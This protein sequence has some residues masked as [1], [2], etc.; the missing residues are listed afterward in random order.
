MSTKM[1]TDSATKPA[2]AP[3]NKPTSSI[4][5]AQ[6]YATLIKATLQLINNPNSNLITTTIATLPK[7]PPTIV[8][9]IANLIGDCTDLF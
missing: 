3:A 1:S 7:P 6:E 5:T 9:T 8:I 4:Q 2:R